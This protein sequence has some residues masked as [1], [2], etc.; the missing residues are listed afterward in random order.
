VVLAR[1]GLAGHRL[2]VSVRRGGA[3]AGAIAVGGMQPRELD[4]ELP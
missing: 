1:G 3:G 2:E 4:Q